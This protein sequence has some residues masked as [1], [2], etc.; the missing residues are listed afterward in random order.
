LRVNMASVTALEETQP[1]KSKAPIRR[2]NS[3]SFSAFSGLESYQTDRNLPTYE[4]NWRQKVG[5]SVRFFCHSKYG[6]GLQITLNLSMLLLNL[7]LIVY[8]F[9]YLRPFSYQAIPSPEWFIVCDI[10][11]VVV[12]FLEIAVRYAEYEFDWRGYF[13]EFGNLGDVLVLLVS[14]AVLIIYFY[15]DDVTA[16]A[17]D[18]LS[19][20]FVRIFRDIVRLFRCV[21]FMFTLYESDIEG[22]VVFETIEEVSWTRFKPRLTLFSSIRGNTQYGTF[23]GEEVITFVE[24]DENQDE[25]VVI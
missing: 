8:E 6:Y 18:N 14:I 5:E 4:E 9:L 2:N 22:V 7:Y 12:L 19:L 17:Q 15:E 10:L 16:R 23:L 3:A 25:A 20:L 1:L 21:W 11:I 24:E 13:R